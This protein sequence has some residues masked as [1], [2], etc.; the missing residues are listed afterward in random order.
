M[1]ISISCLNAACE[2]TQSLIS[3]KDQGNLE[4]VF[5]KIPNGHFLWLNISKFPLLNV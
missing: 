1:I 3:Y 4:S 5:A 2:Y